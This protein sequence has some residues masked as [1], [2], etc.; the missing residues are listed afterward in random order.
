MSSELIRQLI[1]IEHYPRQNLHMPNTFQLFINELIAQHTLCNFD[2]FDI[3]DVHCVNWWP[4]PP[5][6][7]GADPNSNCQQ[8]AL[9]IEWYE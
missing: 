8:F 6:S 3:D 9:G 7:V 1:C 2:A 4:Y 5:L